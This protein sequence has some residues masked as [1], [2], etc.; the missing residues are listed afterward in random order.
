[1][2]IDPDGIADGLPLLRSHLGARAAGAWRLEGERLARLSFDAAPDLPAGVAARFAGATVSV[3]IDRRDL[4]IVAA[5]V[6]GHRVVSIAADLPPGAG[7]GYWLRAFAADRSVAVPIVG[8][9]GAVVGVVSVALAGMGWADDAVE[10]LL[11]DEAAGW[12]IPRR[13]P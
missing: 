12:F 9:D 10:A 7:S 11:T 5:V 2:P 3:P 1:M 6:E 8:E 13:M 4:G